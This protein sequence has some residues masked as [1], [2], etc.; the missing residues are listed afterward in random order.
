MKLMTKSGETP[1]L[2]AFIGRVEPL[3]RAHEENI[4]CGLDSSRH[5]A[6]LLGSAYEPR[7]FRNPFYESERAEMIRAAF[8]NEPRLHILPLEDSNYNLNEWIERTQST[9]N[10]VWDTI[11]VNN[12]DEA[13]KPHVSLIGHSKDATSFYLDLFPKWDSINTPNFHSGLNA[14]AIRH[15]IFGSMAMVQ[16]YLA[17]DGA[18]DPTPAYL[19][20]YG[21]RALQQA[22]MFLSAEAKLAAEGRGDLSSG[23]V[24]WLR[25][26]VHTE[27]KFRAVTDEY[28]FVAKYNW[29]WKDAPYPPKFVTV[30]LCIVKAGRIL[31]VE[32]KG[33]PGKGLLA[34]PGGHLDE[35]ERI[36]TGCV[37]EARE[38]T[39][40][41]VPEAILL[42]NSVLRKSDGSAAT[43]Y[44]DDPFRSSRGRTITHVLFVHLPPGG[45]DPKVRPSSDAKRADW[46]DLSAL[47]RRDFFED[48]YPII[49]NLTARI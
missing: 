16:D 3:T 35:N 7:T 11:R 8:P 26:F 1:D 27:T 29:Q 2:A 48:H 21:E 31:L 42:G 10:G 14:T 39:G 15:K 30:D 49:R 32:R 9:V 6:A 40:L 45:P 33:Y 17:G 41:R 28:A 12:P 19:R 13:K 23:V 25:D 36:I 46:H 4:Q 38:E 37:R 34:M 18:E 5:M 24:S 43:E 22:D 47:N 44:F 20:K